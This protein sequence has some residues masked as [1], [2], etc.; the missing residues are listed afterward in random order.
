MW[1]ITLFLLVPMIE[2]ALFIQIG[3]LLGLWP[4]LAIIIALAFLG[5]WLVRTQGMMAFADL[6]G[7]MAEFRDPTEPAAHGLMILFAGLLL[8]VPGFFTD[9]IGLLLLIRPIRMV[10]LSTMMR[11]FRVA[12]PMGSPAQ[13][14]RQRTRDDIIEGDFIEVHPANDDQRPGGRPSGWTRH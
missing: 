6:Q 1:L 14:G 11:R 9:A 7:A 2:I 5:S 4:T 12:P 3:G 10:A 13:E 8:M